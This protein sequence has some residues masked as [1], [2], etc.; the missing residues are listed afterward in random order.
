M[1][2]PELITARLLLRAFSLHD[3]NE[4]QV[5]SGNYNV[6]RTTLNIPFPYESG[7]AEEWIGLHQSGW[8]EK[9]K[10]VYAITVKETDK[11]VGAIDLVLTEQSQGLLGYWV[12]EPYWGKGY[13]P[14]AAKALLQL[15]FGELALSKVYAEHLTSNPASGRVME[16]IGMHHVASERKKDRNQELAEME[17]Y[18]IR[19]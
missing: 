3:A 4:V 9:S 14:E 5:L 10:V 15:A 2:Q 8:Q 17:V 12:G 1:N 18:E 13:C 6:S 11:L 16:K 19:N 7:M